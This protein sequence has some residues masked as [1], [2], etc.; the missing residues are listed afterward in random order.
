M[1]DGYQAPDAGAADDVCRKGVARV[2][3]R[4]WAFISDQCSLSFASL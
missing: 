1:E 4:L 2:G 3:K